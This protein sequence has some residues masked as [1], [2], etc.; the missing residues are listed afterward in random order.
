MNI[1]ALSS[2]G[3]AWPSEYVDVGDDTNPMAALSAITIGDFFVQNLAQ[4][5]SAVQA[6]GEFA[7]QNEFTYDANPKVFEQSTARADLIPVW[8]KRMH[9]SL[10]SITAHQVAAQVQGFEVTMGLL[11]A[12]FGESR[13]I[14]RGVLASKSGPHAPGHAEIAYKAGIVRVGLPKVFP[15]IVLDSNKNDR[16]F[17]GSL[18][19][20]IKSGQQL[21]L[22]GDFDKYFDL[23]A[24]SNLQIDVL[25][26]LAPNF[27]QILK[28]SSVHFDVE[29][30]GDEMVLLTRDPL[31]TEPVMKVVAEALE[32]Q[33][34]YLGHLLTSWN[35]VPQ[36]TPFDTLRTSNASV[37]N[38]KV[39]PL[40]LGPLTI[41]AI[42]FIFIFMI[43]LF[44]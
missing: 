35:Y 22:E 5:S 3:G 20:L 4:D 29:F 30:F 7:A 2:L 9:A 28:E 42:I 31:Y 26:A 34:A 14:Q 27:M 11:Y 43:Q 44:T 41:I 23:Y 19:A 17:M 16:L 37:T 33:L 36:V 8:Q 18:D 39:G 25:S 32:A 24:P 12:G 38:L 15:Q 21:S 1:T 10:G 13:N 6:I 40:R